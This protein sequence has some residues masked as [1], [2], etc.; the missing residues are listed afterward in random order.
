MNIPKFKYFH[1]PLGHG[2]IEKSEKVC[3]SCQRK[4]GYVVIC[5]VYPDSDNE[6]RGNI[7][8][9]CV[10][11]GVANTRLG[12]SFNQFDVIENI[13]IYPKSIDELLNRT[14]GFPTWN[15]DN[16]LGHCNDLMMFMGDAS[17]GELKQDK[18]Y[19]K[20]YNPPNGLKS[21]L[22]EIVKN[23][24][25]GGSPTFLKFQCIHCSEIRYYVDWT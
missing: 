2:V 4:T 15:Y 13:P 19:E 7:C 14:P 21:V 22:N 24:K 6:F 10:S 11:D 23:Y 20:L 5:S 1:D 9:W 8:P 17:V 3:L 25:P 16:W 18:F 12:V